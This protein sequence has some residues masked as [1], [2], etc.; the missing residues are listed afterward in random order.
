MNTEVTEFFEALESMLEDIE[1]RLRRARG[2][3]ESGASEDEQKAIEHISDSHG[4]V[5]EFRE[6]AQ[7]LAVRLRQEAPEAVQSA[8]ERLDNL[9]GEAS[10]AVRQAVI[11]LAEGVSGGAEGAAKL[12]KAGAARAHDLADDLRKTP[13]LEKPTA[14][15]LD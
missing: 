5:T 1:E 7:N 14:D 12:L 8:R 9:S 2:A 13:D 3:I 6:R 11:L 4:A 15:P 10:S